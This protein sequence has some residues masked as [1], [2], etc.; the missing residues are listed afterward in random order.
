[1]TSSGVTSPRDKTKIPDSTG[2]DADEAREGD[3]DV[4]EDV[5]ETSLPWLL[6]M[7]SIVACS[8]NQ[9]GIRRK[10][11][12]EEEGRRE[13]REWKERREKK[14]IWFILISDAYL[15]QSNW[16]AR[17]TSLIIAWFSNSRTGIKEKWK[18]R[19]LRRKEGDFW[20]W[21]TDYIW[22]AQ[23]TFQSQEQRSQDDFGKWESFS[24]IWN[25]NI[26]NHHHK[27]K[28]EEN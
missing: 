17:R 21:I 12:A 27:G 10:Q 8:H 20:G 26:K 19:M 9:K 13:N 23:S 28:R 18:E 3:I 25:C 5:D 24:S 6:Q 4:E 7:L 14:G 16:L 1:M 22:S 15:S 11:K 2:V